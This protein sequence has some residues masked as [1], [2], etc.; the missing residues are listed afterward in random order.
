MR[1][2]HLPT[3][4]ATMN[5]RGLPRFSHPVM[6]DI[7][8]CSYAMKR[9]WWKPEDTIVK[10]ER[11]WFNLDMPGDALL[12]KACKCSKCKGGKA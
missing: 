11:G 2:T 6:V 9:G 8:S 10:T 7:H 5:D 12:L 4:I 1:V 3:G